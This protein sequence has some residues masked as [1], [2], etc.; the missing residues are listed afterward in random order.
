MTPLHQAA[1]NSHLNVLRRLVESGADVEACTNAAQPMLQ[2]AAIHG[3]ADCVAY[4]VACNCNLEHEDHSGRTALAYATKLARADIVRQLVGGAEARN[5]L[6]TLDAGG[7]V[8]AGGMA[9][10]H[11]S[12]TSTAS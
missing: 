2:V 12:K 11:G 9:T 1:L 7:T 4:L 10:R 3:Q 8:A 6:V 5:V